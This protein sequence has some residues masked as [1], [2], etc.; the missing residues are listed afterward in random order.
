MSQ[1]LKG[2]ELL[3]RLHDLPKNASK[4]D[5]ARACGYVST[6]ADGSERVN[7]TAFYAALLE[8]Q[9]VRLEP[10]HEGKRGRRLSHVTTVLAQGHAVV[11]RP[12][13]EAAGIEPGTSLVVKVHRGRVSLV[14]A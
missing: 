10:A 9:G 3:A 12:Y 1:F 4:T 5:R 7:F 11:G 14:P 8:A 6:K 2:A 13:L